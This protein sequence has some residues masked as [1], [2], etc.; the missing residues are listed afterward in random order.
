MKA[1]RRILGAALSGALLIGALSGCAET[2]A[3]PSASVSPSPSVS[4]SAAP[5]ETPSA[6]QFGDFDLETPD[7]T[8]A[9]LGIPGTTTVMTVDGVDVSAE[10]YLYWLDRVTQYVGVRNF[11]A[12]SAIDWDMDTGNGTVSEYITQN[13]I[14]QELL[15]Q[16]I[17]KQ[18]A[19]RNI[20]I[21]ADEEIKLEQE[22]ADT[23]ESMGGQEGFELALKA[24]NCSEDNLRGIYETF[25]FLYVSLQNQLFPAQDPASITAEELAQWAS[26]N[27]KK[28]GRA[29]V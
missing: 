4:A 22:I 2:A 23:I 21:T 7:V 3:D 15:Y 19:D 12:T 20:T 13:A 5:S 28:I 29:H 24:N 10:E 6:A 1:T 26:D 11:G 9:L 18:C 16:T 27:G 8:M 14:N 17:R 25:D